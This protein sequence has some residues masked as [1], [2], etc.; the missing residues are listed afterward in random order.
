MNLGFETYS[1]RIYGTTEAPL[2]VEGGDTT[3]GSSPCRHVERFKEEKNRIFM[4]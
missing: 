2:G 3:R 1:S 4:R